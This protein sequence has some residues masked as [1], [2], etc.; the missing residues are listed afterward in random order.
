MSI[1]GHTEEEWDALFAET[2]RV[3]AQPLK[4]NAFNA[5]PIADHFGQVF[6]LSPTIEPPAKE[7][8][9]FEI[10]RLTHEKWRSEKEAEIL[11]R[12]RAKPTPA[13]DDEQR[14]A[15]EALRLIVKAGMSSQ[16]ARAVLRLRLPELAARLD[17]V[18]PRPDW[19]A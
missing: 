3:L 11:Q 2:R 15:L 14:D 18:V 1:D 10:N 5:K 4:T 19:W 16:R 7:T 6:A 12:Q 9:T 13:T 17:R 8:A